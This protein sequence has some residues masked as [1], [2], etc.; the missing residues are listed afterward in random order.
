MTV[1][2][3]NKKLKSTLGSKRWFF[4]KRINQIVFLEQ[5]ENTFNFIF[6]LTT[7]DGAHTGEVYDFQLRQAISFV[8]HNRKFEDREVFDIKR[9]VLSGERDYK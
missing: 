9:K 4:E 6:P 5:L 2:E 3:A 8:R 1:P 7:P